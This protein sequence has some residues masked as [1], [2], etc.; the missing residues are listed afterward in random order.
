MPLPNEP[1]PSVQ[2]GGAPWAFTREQQVLKL[3]SKGFSTDEVAQAMG[4]SRTTV[5]TFVRRIY[6][7]LE[8]NTRAEAIHEAHRKGLLAD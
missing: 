4:V 5:R 1:A 3:V 8:V 6:A 2:R 7:K